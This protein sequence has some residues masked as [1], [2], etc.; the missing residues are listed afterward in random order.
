M[1]FSDFCTYL[2]RLEQTTKR[3]EITAILA[4]LIKECDAK[5]L[6]KAIYLSLGYLSAPFESKKFNIA[7][8]MMLR[9]L[10][11]LYGNEAEVR[12]SYAQSG[13]LGNVAFKLH[14]NKSQSDLD[15]LQVH[16]KL[17]LIAQLEG[18]GSQD[19][20]ITKLVELLGGLSALSAKYLVRIVLGTTR[21]GF[22]EL[23]IADAL[24][25]YLAGNKSLK[26]AI[27]S[28]YFIYPDIGKIAKII[29]QNGIAGLDKITLDPGVPVL[30]QK[31]QRLGG[32]AETIQK[33]GT[34][35]AEFKFDG[36]R[37]QL[38]LDKNK[39]VEQNSLFEN[40]PYLVK[41]F[42]RNLEESTHQFPD[43]VEHAM[44]QI[45][46][47]SIILDGEAMGINTKTGE[48]LPFQQ[49]MQRKRKHS[50]K[51]MAAEIPLVYFAFD[52]LYLNGKSLLDLSLEQRHRLLE[53]V[54]V[55]NDSFKIA[56]HLETTNEEELQNYFNHVK[57]L[58]LE[59]LIVKKPGDPYQ[60]GARSFSWVKLKIADEKLLDD[61]I[62]A[63]VLGYYFGKGV[64]SKFG[65]G[66]FLIGVYDDK[67]EVFKTISKVGTGLKDEDWHILKELADK[68][69][70]DKVP[71][72]VQLPK[73]YAPDVICVPKIVVEIG[74]DEISV[75]KTHSA[76]YA[77]RFPR[78]LYFRTDKKADQITAL[79]EIIHLY[80][81]KK[82]GRYSK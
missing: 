45:K 70:T 71:T 63:V 16:E 53:N 33:M 68:H 38:H 61:S 10:E 58:G 3:L 41:T 12:S 36:T 66:G 21:L 72:N 69:K 49:I 18:A 59:G 20:K 57:E 25:T 43:I 22:T 42:T 75:S 7:D 17:V 2:Q 73:L 8:K 82:A 77:L 56:A 46:A 30:V 1:H 48:F 50:V 31:P 4:E 64:R 13:D 11:S 29:R 40:T 54:I 74:A 79:K 55:E 78:L 81:L 15:I 26:E 44:T 76:G 37:V 19:K 60:A 62:D 80:G 65:I 14:K 9:A 39:T 28:K 27:E 51:E 47:D 52:I 35:W 24:S 5:S 67:E 23:T 34:C 32:V 6:D